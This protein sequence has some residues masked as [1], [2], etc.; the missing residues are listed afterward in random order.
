M[1][2]KYDDRLKD[3]VDV[4]ERVRLFY[5]KHPD[6][7]LV[8]TDVRATTE[9]DGVPRVWVEAAAY[10]TADDPL[11]ARGWSW[12]VLPGSTPYTKGSEIENAETSAWGRAIGA[13][14]IGIAA[15]IASSDEVRSKQVTAD[16]EHGDDGSLIGVVQVGDKI[17]SDYSIRPLADGRASLGFR[18][19]G[20]KGGILVEATGTL[21]EQ[22]YEHKDRIVGARVTVWGT[23]GDRTFPS[24]KSTVKYQALSAERVSVPILGLLPMEPDEPPAEAESAPLFDDTEEA[25]IAQALGVTA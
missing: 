23:V 1:S 10:R 3:Y 25:A 4:K 20:D 9:P 12:L 17:T 6:G 5:E 13:L 16:V 15:S 11:P 7:R 14:G 8:T 18:L 24:G 22:L 21:A 2:G 19:R